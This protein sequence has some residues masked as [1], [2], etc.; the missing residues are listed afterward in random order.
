M[1]EPEQ[2]HAT[3]ELFV[4]DGLWEG[5]RR[6]EPINI[7][8]FEKEFGDLLNDE[9]L[10]RELFVST[11][12]IKAWLKKGEI[13]ADKTLPLGR[14]TL[15]YFEPSQ[16]YEIRQ[17]K[18]LKERTD[19][20]RYEDFF[21]FLEQRDYTFSYKIAFLLALLKHCDE[22]GEANLEEV[23]ITYQA[24]YLQVF[25][26]FGKVEKENN[27]LNDKTKLDDT[28]YIQRSMLQN[29]FEKFERKRFMYQCQDLALISFDAVLWEKLTEKDLDKVRRQYIEDGISYFDK[30]AIKLNEAYFSNIFNRESNEANQGVVLENTA[31]VV[32][33][34]QLQG[35]AQQVIEEDTDKVEIPLFPDIK[36]ACGHFKTG[37]ADYSE[38]MALGIEYGHLNPERHF[39]AYA[40]GN[41]MN[42]GK[43]PIYDGDL[44][45]L[46]RVTS[47]S[48]GSISGNTMVI[49]QQDETGDN[50]YLL[51]V[52]K[53][54]NNGTYL[55]RAQNTSPDYPDILANESFRTL[56]RLRAKVD[57]SHYLY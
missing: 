42:G 35:N 48:A 40:S 39:L 22:Q 28:K 16:V 53:K 23:T 37:S 21:E 29:P 6:L 20:S 24:F 41:S 15:N 56:A 33:L 19:A 30:L 45:L 14:S 49:E 46:E 26:Q 2:A 13:K 38:T 57:N 11:G 44:L 7:F 31:E 55:L 34:D 25:N 36:I 51:R 1:I 17:L 43:N 9:Q 18:G 5:E 32:P 27:P 50:Q 10:A 54:Q 47:S 3:N 8:N 12:T 52:V 4:F